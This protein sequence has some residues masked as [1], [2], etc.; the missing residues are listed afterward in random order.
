MKK[1]NCNL[2]SLTLK[3]LQLISGSHLNSLSVC[4][5]LD[6]GDTA[7]KKSDT[8]VHSLTLFF[9]GTGGRQSQLGQTRSKILYMMFRK[10]VIHV[11][12]MNQDSI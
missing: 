4:Y 11:I 7:V 6:T 2:G 9:G 5:V 10:T 1:I 12:R 8:S 3:H